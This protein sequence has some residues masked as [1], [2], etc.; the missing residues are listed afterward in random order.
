MILL[1]L[2]GAGVLPVH[3]AQ[4]TAA[5]QP[6][7]PVILS[8]VSPQSSASPFDSLIG[9]AQ[10]TLLFDPVLSAQLAQPAP[11]PG[12]VFR[13]QSVSPAARL[14]IVPVTVKNGSDIMIDGL[15]QEDFTVTEDGNPQQISFFEFENV[16]KDHRLLALYFDMSSTP[17]P[18]QLRALDAARKF[19]STQMSGTDM[20]S[21]IRYTGTGAGAEVLQDFTG[22]RG[23]LLSVIAKMTLGAADAPATT[24]AEKLNALRTAVMK[25][26]SLREKK[27]LVYFSAGLNLS[28][29]D[30]QAALRLTT[31][32][33]VR[34]GGSIWPA[35]LRA[36]TR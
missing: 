4:K 13:A 24:P 12:P 5:S 6:T 22:D 30:N 7:H 35:Q 18:D 1:L 3:G 34:A 16:D 32:D 2:A 11:M 17:V 9:Q 26:G 8:T 19:V 25:L 33:A 31:N 20:L 36:T 21:L 14:V 28:P 10:K 29:M 23:R 15:R 27:S